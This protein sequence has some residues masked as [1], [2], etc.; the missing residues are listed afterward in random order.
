MVLKYA[1]TGPC[2]T[3]KANHVATR[4]CSI[5]TVL[6][7][8]DGGSEA[9]ASLGVV[10]G[11]C[12]TIAPPRVANAGIDTTW[13]ESVDATL[14]VAFVVVDVVYVTTTPRDVATYKAMH[15]IVDTTLGT[16][17]IATKAA[18][19]ATT[20]IDATHKKRWQHETNVRGETRKLELLRKNNPLQPNNMAPTNQSLS[21]WI[22]KQITKCVDRRGN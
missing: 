14:G 9:I 8:A 1:A 6:G 15:V 4:Q 12:E 20:P 17:L 13:N 3:R 21:H 19:V 10:D 22:P 11:G 2:A 18:R 7:I 5:A 16:A